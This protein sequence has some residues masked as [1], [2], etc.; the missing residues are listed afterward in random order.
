MAR[1]NPAIFEPF[2]DPD[3]GEWIRVKTGTYENVVWRP[4]DMQFDEKEEGKL[5]FR[6]EMLEGENLPKVDENDKQFETVCGK[7]IVDI[8][9]ATANAGQ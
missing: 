4:V 7:I 5:N 8:F 9:E 2:I 6:I 1:I 3:G